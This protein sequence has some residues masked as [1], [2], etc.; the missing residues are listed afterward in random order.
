MVRNHPALLAYIAARMRAPFAWGKAANDCVSF[1]GGAVEAQTGVDRL[2][3]L[4]SWTTERGAAR[5]LRRL[6]GLEAAVDGVLTS[7]PPSQAARGDV[8]G[9]RDAKGRL[10][11]AI[12]EGDTIIGPGMTG[13]VRLPRTAMARAWSAI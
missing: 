3:V 1:A 13:L 12:V 5:V 7:L 6:G 4:P 2:G 8:A 11:L 9:W 10:Q